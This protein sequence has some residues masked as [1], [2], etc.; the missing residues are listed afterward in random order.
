MVGQGAG[1]LKLLSNVATSEHLPKWNIKKIDTNPINI[2][3][4]LYEMH[5]LLLVL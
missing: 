5:Q 1:L 3:R 2:A 4:G